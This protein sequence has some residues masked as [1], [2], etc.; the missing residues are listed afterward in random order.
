MHVDPAEL[1]PRVFIA[2][3]GNLGDV[4]ATFRTALTRLSACGARVVR[5]SRAYQTE[6][7][8][9]PAVAAASPGSTPPPPY[10]NAVCEVHTALL[11]HALLALLLQIEREAGRVRSVRWASRSLDLDLVLYGSLCLTTP[12]LVLPHPGVL[13]RPFVLHPLH[14]IDPDL[15]IPPN[16]GP[17]RAYVQTQQVKRTDV[18]GDAPTDI[19]SRVEHNAGIMDVI[20]NWYSV[21]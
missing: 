11:P 16:H 14:D 17:V 6:A 12:D 13:H 21:P 2:L 19:A 4:L 15:V 5:V 9:D 10:W 3:G 20:D 18:N 1:P 7:W 8:V